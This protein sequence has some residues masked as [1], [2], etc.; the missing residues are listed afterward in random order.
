MSD[1]GGP[2]ANTGHSLGARRG[3]GLALFILGVLVLVPSGLCS[4]ILLLS[5][6]SGSLR[7][8]L[9]GAWMVLLIGGPFILV[10]GALVFVGLRWR[11]STKQRNL[12]EHF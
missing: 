2:G 4:G 1:P 10:G 12:H 9:G 5:V 3:C 11:K 8:V 7:D 6:L